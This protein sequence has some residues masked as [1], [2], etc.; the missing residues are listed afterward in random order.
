LNAVKS[1]KLAAPSTRGLLPQKL[2]QHR[3]KCK[4]EEVELFLVE[5][6]SAA[7]PCKEIRLPFQEVLELRG[8]L[9]NAERATF[10]AML[11]SPSVMGIIISMG[12][13]PG[14]E[15]RTTG[16]SVRVGRVNIMTDADPDGDHICSLLIALFAKYFPQWIE[17]GRIAHV[18]LPLFVGAYGDQK[19]FGFTREEMLE[20]FPVAK[21]K[22]VIVNRLKGLG[23]ATNS[24]LFEFGMNPK[25]RH[26]KVFTMSDV[27]LLEV[28]KIMGSEDEHKD[29]R[30]EIL[31][32]TAKG[33][34]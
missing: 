14:D 27:D 3:G 4:P 19:E 7:G 1:I 15:C 33:A 13:K 26:C 5:G 21:R 22:N 8:K 24:E 12:V 29:Y 9:L 30:K 32:I 6:E 34:R 20:K 10:P 16:G 23:E 25:T 17:E 28:K 2:A 11:N 31:G 18:Y